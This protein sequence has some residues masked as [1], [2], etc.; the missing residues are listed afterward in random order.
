[1]AFEEFLF[2]NDIWKKKLT[3]DRRECDEYFNDKM[4][5]LLRPAQL[6]GFLGTFLFLCRSRGQVSTETFDFKP[7][8]TKEEN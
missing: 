7:N 5:Q 8:V 6:A 2:F 1:M 4:L 3:K